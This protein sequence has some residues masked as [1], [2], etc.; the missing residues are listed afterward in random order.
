M[1][2]QGGTQEQRQR[3]KA[4]FP[5]VYNERNVAA[6]KDTII[7]VWEKETSITYL[8]GPEESSLS[9]AFLNIVSVIER[10]ILQSS[11]DYRADITKQRRGIWPSIT[12]HEFHDFFCNSTLSMTFRLR[13]TTFFVYNADCTKTQWSCEL[14]KLQPSTKLYQAQH[15]VGHIVLPYVFTRL[16]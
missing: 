9:L 1:V 15:Y 10:H 8:E 7:G 3:R 13:Q 2:C 14:F 11:A 16:N 6:L 12:Q 4:F 5:L